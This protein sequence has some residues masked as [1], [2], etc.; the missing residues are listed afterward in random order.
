LRKKVQSFFGKINF[1]MRFV[2]DYATIEKP[3]NVLLK[4]DHKF[5]W[6]QEIQ[7]SF[8]KIKHEITLALVLFSPIFD[9]YFII[10]SFSS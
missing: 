5:E 6:T 8:I 4:K 1:V 9:Q 10:Y 2:L 7:R 3:I